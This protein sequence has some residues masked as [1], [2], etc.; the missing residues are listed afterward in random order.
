VKQTIQVVVTN[1]LKLTVSSIVKGFTW[2][3]QQT[4]FTSK[5]FLIPLNYCD[6]VL[7]IEWLITL[8][9]IMWNFDKLVMELRIKGKQHVLRGV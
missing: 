4:N 6:L 5:M 2:T 3:I 7:L 9:N 8:G 1:G